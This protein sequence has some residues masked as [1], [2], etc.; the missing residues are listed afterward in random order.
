MKVLPLQYSGS[1]FFKLPVFGAA[2]GD[3]RKGSH[4]RVQ[5]EHI[6]SIH[7]HPMARTPRQ[8]QNVNTVFEFDT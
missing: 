3:A 8:I 2:P 4:I 1:I 7:N 6:A 5:E